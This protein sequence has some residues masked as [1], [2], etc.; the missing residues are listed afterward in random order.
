MGST[1]P[2][3]ARYVDHLLALQGRC[4]PE[5]GRASGIKSNRTDSCKCAAV[6]LRVR[7]LGGYSAALVRVCTMGMVRD[8]YLVKGESNVR[9]ESEVKVTAR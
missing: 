5:S 6:L 1:L 9:G 7:G 4:K 3:S 2:T 8:L